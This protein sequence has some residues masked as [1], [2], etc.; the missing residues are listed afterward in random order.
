M[1]HLS[2]VSCL[3]LDSASLASVVGEVEAVG[4]YENNGRE[5][6]GTLHRCFS[7]DTMCVFQILFSNI[8]V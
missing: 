8:T 3:Q 4:L 6:G 2:G 1:L 5:L 7:R